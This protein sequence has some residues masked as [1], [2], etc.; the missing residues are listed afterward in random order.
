M[1]TVLDILR[2]PWPWYVAGPALGLVVP[3]LLFLANRNFGLSSNLQHICAM[4][5]SRASY[6]RY[7]W[8]SAGG[9]N[10]LV[11]AGIAA[12]GYLAGVLLASPQPVA[13]SDATRAD[14]AALGVTQDEGLAPGSLFGAD[15]LG[16]GPVLLTLLVGGMLIGFGTRWASGC[17]S[18]HAIMGLA[19][20]Q[21]LSLVAVVGFFVGGLV[22][23]HL[24][25]PWL[26]PLLVGR[27]A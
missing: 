24:L 15:A 16:R 8:R 17:T 7:D 18:G 2:E 26:L 6:L 20:R 9:W 19:S 23:T 25:L 1:S 12:G 27:G 4:L 22:M 3:L 5:P 14:L 11:F 21:W 13:L 10:L